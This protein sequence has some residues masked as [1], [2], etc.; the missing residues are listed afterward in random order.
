MRVLHF[1]VHGLE[2]HVR[3]IYVWNKLC[4]TCMETYGH[5]VYMQGMT[6]DRLIE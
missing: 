1:Q 5:P 6:L 3:A 4:L 2:I